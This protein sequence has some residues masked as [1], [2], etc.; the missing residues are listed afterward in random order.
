[1]TS[2]IQN[3]K[4]EILLCPGQ[5]AQAVGMGKAWFD[6][7]PVAAQT[8]A[9]ANE[10]LGFSLSELCFDGPAEKLNRTDMAQC[11]SALRTGSK[12]SCSSSRSAARSPGAS[13]VS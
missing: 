6:A 10:A 12:A 9:A 2:E 13:P 4:S 11:A 1:M 3:L 7:H 5:G 8:F